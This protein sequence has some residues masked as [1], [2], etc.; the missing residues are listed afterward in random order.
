MT[1]KKQWD[2]IIIGGGAAGLSAAQALGRSLRRTLVLDAGSPRNRFAANVHNTLGHDGKTPAEL[3]AVG[4]AEAEQYGVEFRTGT[5]QTVTDIEGG[6]RV[7]FAPS[8]GGADCDEASAN[9]AVETFETRAL[10][11]ATG[12]RDILPDIAGLADYWGRCVLHC[13]YCHGWEVRGRRLGVIADSPASLGKAK[14]LRQWS[15]D[16]TIFSAG[17]GDIDEATA[18][19]FAARNVRL[20][21][22]PV[23]EVQGDGTQMTAIVTADGQSYPID[24]VFAMGA[25]HPI[26]E[27][28]SE[29][30]LT[31]EAGMW[32]SFIATDA[33]GQTS[34]PR[35][36]AVGNVVDPVATVPV[37]MGSGAMTGA[38]ANMVLINEDYEQA[39]QHA[40]A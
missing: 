28:L 13:P 35:I 12:V 30:Q 37:V 2:A 19:G 6:L 21:P 31:R 23:A 36:W 14:M 7:T 8:T 5:V 40:G 3:V 27:F 10:I 34:H 24:A 29:L 16:L 39:V 25:M 1:Q 18:R 33:M 32:G 20:V 26:D 11:V 9:N 38:I 22:S 4:R 17:M 15:D